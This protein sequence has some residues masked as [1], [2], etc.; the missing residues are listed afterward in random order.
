M[1]YILLLCVGILV[2]TIVC[3]SSINQKD[4]LSMLF[5]NNKNYLKVVT[6]TPKI[7]I[8]L[9]NNKL[10]PSSDSISLS[11]L[12]SNNIPV[13]LDLTFNSRV[14]D[15]QSFF[16][17]LISKNLIISV[18]NGKKKRIFSFTNQDLKRTLVMKNEGGRNIQIPFSE[19]IVGDKI[20]LTTTVDTKTNER[21]STRITII[22]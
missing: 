16:N 17:T 8:N 14:L 4:T 1:K 7:Q 12:T 13:I 11:E 20:I 10:H 19:L 22:K 9:N 21:I 2:A 5:L 6:V 3:W 15:I 18:D